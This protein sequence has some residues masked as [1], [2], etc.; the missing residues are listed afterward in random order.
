MSRESGKITEDGVNKAADV[1]IWS[2]PALLPG[3]N[4]ITLDS[5]WVD[6]TVKYRPRF[7]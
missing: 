7:M 1:D 2:L 3:T 5:T 4:Q 6:L